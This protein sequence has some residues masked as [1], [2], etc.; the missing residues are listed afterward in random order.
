Y[1][2]LSNVYFFN[3]NAPDVP[4]LVH[5][6][7]QVETQSVNP[8]LWRAEISNPTAGQT[9]ILKQTYHPGW[10]AYALASTGTPGLFQ[11][12]STIFLGKKLTDHILVDNWANGWSLSQS[13]LQI[14]VIFTP[15]LLE[16]TGFLLLCNMVLILL[17]YL[18]TH[19]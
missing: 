5:T 9:L 4:P 10:Q 6:F 7:E 17:I 3:G 18:K 12:L 13:N 14:I 16:Y 1:Q 19:A 2:F 8:S 11:D 15:Q